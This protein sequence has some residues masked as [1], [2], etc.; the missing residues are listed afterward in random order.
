MTLYE[1]M[2]A[3]A[4]RSRWRAR[5]RAAMKTVVKQFVE[6][7]ICD[8]HQLVPL[9]DA[10]YPF[11]QRSHHPYKA[12]LQERRILLEVID[13]TVPPPAPTIEDYAACDVATDLVEM[14]RE[15]EAKKLL[16]EQAPRR[17]NRKCPACSAPVG[18]PCREKIINIEEQQRR[19]H[20][21]MKTLS[22]LNCAGCNASIPY[23]H[24]K[25]PFTPEPLET[26]VEKVVPHWARVHVPG[27]REMRGAP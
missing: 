15:D 8:Y 13:P 10:A 1:W 12:W 18:V 9:V 23:P 22:S 21:C 20:T 3:P 16:D 2:D 25:D 17:L 5:S 6:T 26:W 14:K 7:G 19:A 27:A 11:G 4:P 24:P